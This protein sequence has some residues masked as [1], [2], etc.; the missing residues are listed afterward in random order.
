MATFLGFEPLKWDFSE[1]EIVSK[2]EHREKIKKWNEQQAE[3]GKKKSG[4]RP[5]MKLRQGL[6]GFYDYSLQRTYQ[7]TKQGSRYRSLVA[8]TMI[9]YKARIPLEELRED[10]E[11]LLVHFNSIGDTF[12][13]KEIDKALRTYN[14]RAEK[15]RSTTLEELFD[16]EFERWREKAAARSKKKKR[17]Q[18]EHLKFAR[19]MK[20]VKKEMDEMQAEGRP[21]K[22]KLV[23]KW[24]TSHP[25]GKKIDCERET[26]LSR[27]T[28]LKWWDEA[29]EQGS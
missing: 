12:L 22:Q 9:G 23:I 7:K 21:N 2:Q 28:V 16:W 20:K 17:S 8:L 18:T 13:P 1:I 15:V 6:K 11:K 27:K 19:T 29:D 24:R 14:S 25:E 3:G 5:K 26:G 10:F 4:K